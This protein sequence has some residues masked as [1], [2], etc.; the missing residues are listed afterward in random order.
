[1]SF[2]KK[3]II[4]RPNTDTPWADTLPWATPEQAQAFI[5]Y[6]RTTYI[7]TGRLTQTVEDSADN[8]TR[9]ITSVFA[10][11]EDWQANAADPQT[12]AY[13]EARADWCAENGVILTTETIS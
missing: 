1:M 2:V 6:R 8:L 7:D 13:H 12:V 5:D 10:S 9:T 11:Q 3:I 4:I